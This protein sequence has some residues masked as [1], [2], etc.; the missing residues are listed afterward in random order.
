MEWEKRGGVIVW[1]HRDGVGPAT[2]W[3][4]LCAVELARSVR[5]IEVWNNGSIDELHWDVLEKLKR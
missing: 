5:L 1:I 4:R 3:E 2:D